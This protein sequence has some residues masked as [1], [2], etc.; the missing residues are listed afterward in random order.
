MTLDRLVTDLRDALRQAMA[1][2]PHGTGRRGQWV[3]L[4]WP[5][6]IHVCLVIERSTTAIRTTNRALLADSVPIDGEL[7]EELARWVVLDAVQQA[8]E[9]GTSLD[10]PA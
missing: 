9:Y 4:R 7:P 2:G 5:A 8:R 1:D 6:W 3:A 10:L